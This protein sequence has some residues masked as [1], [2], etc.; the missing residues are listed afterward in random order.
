MRFSNRRAGRVAVVATAAFVS[1]GA[2]AGSALAA[3]DEPDLQMTL[4]EVTTAA[5]GGVVEVRSVI[6]NVSSQAVDGVLLNMSLPRYVSFAPTANCQET[7]ENA[8]GGTLVS[9]NISG[10]EGQL[11][12]GESVESV[13]PFQIAPE[14]PV[15]TQL[16]ALGALVVPLEGGAEPVDDWKDLT[17]H[18]VAELPISTSLGEAASGGGVWSSITG[19]FS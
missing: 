3:G 13:T 1:F 15:D 4:T 14:A 7:G 16:G 11:A 19:F 8:E 2:L 6:E 12:P 17:G 18:N 5:P 9:C 10:P